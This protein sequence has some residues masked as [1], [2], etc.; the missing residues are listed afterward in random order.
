MRVSVLIAAAGLAVVAAGVFMSTHLGLAADANDED[1]TRRQA[2]QAFNDG[3]WKDAL[4]SFRKLA[5]NSTTNAQQVSQDLHQAVQCLNQLGLQTEFDALVEDSIEAHAENWR[6]LQMAGR[7]YR[8][9]NHYGF[10]VTGEFERGGRR[11]RG[12]QANAFDRDFV[13]ALQLFDTAWKLAVAAEASPE[14]LRQIIDEYAQTHRNRALHS[15]VWALQRLTDLTQLPDYEEGYWYGHRGPQYGGAPV[16]ADGSPVFYSVP[17]SFEAAESDGERWRW[18]LAEAGRLVPAWQPN[19]DI[20]YADFLW[21]QFGVQTLASYGWWGRQADDASDRKAGKFS[22]HTLDDNETI[23]KLASGV[24]RIRLPDEHNFLR[25]YRSLADADGGQAVR[26]RSQLA[27]ILENRRQYPKA[28]SEW[29]ALVERA[30]SKQHWQHR[31]DQIVGNWGQFETTR[32]QA[33]GHAASVDYRYRNGDS[34]QFEAFPIDVPKLLADVKAYLKNNPKE[35]DWQ[36]VQIGQIGHRIVTQNQQKYVGSRIAQW[37][38]QL[39]PAENHNDRRVTV[40][41]PLQQPGAYLVEAKI[42]D[43]NTSRIVLWVDDTVIVKKPLDEEVLYFVAD[44]ESGHPIAG[45]NLEFFGWKSEYRQ[46]PRQHTVLTRNFAEHS[47][48]SGFVRL[49]DGR[50]ARNFQ[51]LTIARTNQGRFAFHGFDRIWFGRQYDREYNATKT[52]VITDRPVYRPGQTVQFKFWVRHTQ[53][54]HPDV[55]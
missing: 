14:E 27:Q 46:K 18:L 54:D 44:A 8:D 38:L 23:A 51:W 3:N 15:G 55:S 21:Q 40:N 13:R 48:H 30:H 49:E 25:I 35:I 47:D 50:A 9:G 1:S 41:T 12:K 22:V 16:N 2:Q 6:L 43:G 26:A 34:V 17:E 37:S 7:Q 20:Q 24:S 32:T 33:S 28:A 31:L 11:G 39:D 19:Y 36:T 10:I 29:R 52:F 42:N 5:A 45:A 53:Y 4:T